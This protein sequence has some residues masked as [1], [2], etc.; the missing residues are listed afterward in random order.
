MPQPGPAPSHTVKP[1][2]SA[3]GHCLPPHRHTPSLTKAWLQGAENS[4]LPTIHL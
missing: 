4:S 2:Q 1:G 3:A